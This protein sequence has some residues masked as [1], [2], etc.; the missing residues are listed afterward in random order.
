MPKLVQFL[1]KYY[2][3]PKNCQGLL[4]FGHT[5]NLISSGDVKVHF[6]NMRLKKP[7]FRKN[8]YLLAS[9]LYLQHISGYI[10]WRTLP[11]SISSPSPNWRSPILF[12][13]FSS[14]TN[15]RQKH[16]NFF[17]CQNQFFKKFFL[18]STRERE[19]TPEIWPR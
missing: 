18:F 14:N 12:N 15:K 13:N 2:L 7:L 16:S 4:Y 6:F 17:H 11:K 8:N 10:I 19:R 5:F 9:P 1:S 3:N